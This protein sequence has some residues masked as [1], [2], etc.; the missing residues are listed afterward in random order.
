MKIEPSKIVK[1]YSLYERNTHRFEIYEWVCA[2]KSLKEEEL[3]V[4]KKSS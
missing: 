2:H 4:V 3:R 1:H